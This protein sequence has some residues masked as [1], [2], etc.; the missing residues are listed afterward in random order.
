MADIPLTCLFINNSP[1]PG[2]KELA[3]L[4]GGGKSLLGLLSHLPETG[5]KTHVVVPGEG[6]FTDEL[7]KIHIPHTIYPFKQI[8]WQ[9]PLASLSTTLWWNKLFRQIRPSLIHAN[10]FELSRSFAVAAAISGI[11]YITHVRFPVD[12]DGARWTLRS[13]PKPAAFIFNS[14][15]MMDSLWP[16]LSM[17]A[18][19]SKAYVAHNAVDL[20]NFTPA[21]WPDGPTLR[22]GI[23][24][25]FAP[26][27]RHEDFL[28]MA[29]EMISERQ[30]LEFWVVGEDTQGTGR[31]AALEQLAHELRVDS[32]VR[33]LGHRSDIPDIMRQLH[34]LVVPS[35]FEP[36][37]RVVIEA[38][39][40]GRPVI[41]SHDGGI[42]EIIEE[43]KTGYLIEL[44]DW[45]GFARAALALLAD[46][47]KWTSMSQSASAAAR[48]RFSI[49]AH[50][51]QIIGI[52]REIL[53][54][55]YPAD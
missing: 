13:L 30:D 55:P 46:R 44:G 50:V 3:K 48:N 51:T 6:Q 14:H 2:R 52:Y 47:E 27:K 45:K 40:C 54:Q 38:M 43:G 4:G 23:V 42:P 1:Q 32:Y 39:A 19:H 18:P 9:Q 21:P 5:W 7:A 22:I 20:V 24:A 34:L 33:F 37:G 10:G 8:G 16:N 28:R 11:P 41:G 26:F 25:N 35:Q 36:F 17:L 29:A 12:P 53:G 49:A 15:A 31:R